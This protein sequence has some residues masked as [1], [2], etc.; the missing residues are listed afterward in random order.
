MTE[1]DVMTSHWALEGRN[2]RRGQNRGE[3]QA[4]LACTL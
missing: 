3:K 1:K 4:D 2:E